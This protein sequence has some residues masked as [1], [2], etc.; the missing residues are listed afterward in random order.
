MGI[1]KV[2]KGNH[3]YSPVVIRPLTFNKNTYY[4]V[5]V[6]ARFDRSSAVDVQPGNDDQFNKLCGIAFNLLNP[7]RNSVMCGWRYNPTSKKFELTPYWHDKTGKN[8][9]FTKDLY[10]VGVDELFY[11]DF[12]ITENAEVQVAFER[13]RSIANEYNDYVLF[14]NLK[15]G[16]EPTKL[17]R[18]I[19]SWFGGQIAAPQD[20]QHYVSRF[21]TNSYIFSSTLD[22]WIVK[23]SRD[24]Y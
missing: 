13:E 5:S 23:R 11:I 16:P 2:K 19:N 15:P 14:D 7:T 20:M 1:F 17:A 24:N 22:K 18:H 21:H 9:F 6:A 4:T 8:H 3:A 12:I 10:E